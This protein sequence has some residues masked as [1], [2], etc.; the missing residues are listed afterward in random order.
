M[1]SK[2]YIGIITAALL[3]GL[4]VQAQIDESR[5]FR[6][7][8]AN[9]IVNN[10]YNYDY[11]YSSRINRF[12][13]SFVTFDYYAPLFTD[14]FWYNYEPSSWGLSIYGG[15]RLGLGFSFN[16]PLYNDFSWNYP[17]YGGSYYWGYDPFYY[18]RWYSPV[19]LNLGIWSRWNRNYYSWQGHNRWNYEYKPVYNNF[20]DYRLN[21]YSSNS[22][23]SRHRESVNNNSPISNVS[24]REGSNYTQTEIT[25]SNRSRSENSGNVNINNGG[26]RR[27]IDPSNN[28]NSV[29]N[30]R[31]KNPINNSKNLNRT[32]IT[33]QNNQINRRSVQVSGN[34]QSN[35]SNRSGQSYLNEKTNS[36]RTIQKSE[37]PSNSDRRSNVAS[38]NKPASGSLNSA[39][40]SSSSAAKQVS[41]RAGQRSAAKS[42]S[43]TSS[44]R[45]SSKGNTK[46]E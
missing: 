41:S 11:Y 7:D 28:Q 17:Y 21:D 19:V 20:R 42:A 27:T 5:D 34:N 36:T 1:K 8:D 32:V 43:K 2:L 40:K 18:N 23:Y 44:K 16:Y 25:K 6:N 26:T 24:R 12:H 4:I 35:V 46:K 9:T 31:L 10:Y 13:R 3:P 45:S 30:N 15:T 38:L 39:S 33:P 22:Y 37:S 29:I 14:S